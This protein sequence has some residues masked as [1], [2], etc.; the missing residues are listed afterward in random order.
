MIASGRYNLQFWNHDKLQGCPINN[1]NS[2]QLIVYWNYKL[3][4][5]PNDANTINKSIKLKISTSIC[6]KPFPFT[7]KL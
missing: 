2:T 3:H 6:V 4:V 1:F 5:N 7:F